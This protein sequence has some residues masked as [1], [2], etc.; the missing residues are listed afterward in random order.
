MAA[1]P[2]CACHAAQAL[3]G[4]PLAHPGSSLFAPELLQGPSIGCAEKRGP[5]AAPAWI[6]LCLTLKNRLPSAQGP[7]FEFLEKHPGAAPYVTGIFAYNYSALASLGLSASALSGSKYALPKVVAGITRQVGSADANITGMRARQATAR[8]LAGRSGSWHTP[9]KT[10]TCCSSSWHLHPACSWMP[11]SPTHCSLPRL[12][13]L[14]IEDSPAVLEDY[15][16]YREEE[17][18]GTWPRAE[19]AAPGA[20]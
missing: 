14:F 3:L 13:Q 12:L 18:V 11:G 15:L 19:P 20:A 7:S 8:F 10:T 5:G 2:W 16:N 1:P 9:S 6:H 4:A 17:F